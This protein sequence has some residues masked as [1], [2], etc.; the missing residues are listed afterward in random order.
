MLGLVRVFPAVAPPFMVCSFQGSHF[1]SLWLASG[2]V[3]HSQHQTL[4]RPASV[5]PLRWL[6][7]HRHPLDTEAGEGKLELLRIILMQMLTRCTMGVDG[8]EHRLEANSESPLQVFVYC[9]KTCHVFNSY[10][11]YL[12]R[13]LFNLKK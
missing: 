6:K 12:F 13:M 8:F 2:M 1:S 3:K 4:P 7:G 10:M 11:S 9:A 5:G